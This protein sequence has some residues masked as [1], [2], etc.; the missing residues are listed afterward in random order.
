MKYFA[1]RNRFFLIVAIHFLLFSANVFAQT[2]TVIIEKS[3]DKVVI[4]GKIYFIHIVQAGHTLHSIAKVYNVGVDQIINENPSAQH[5]IKPGQALKIPQVIRHI[6]YNEGSNKLDDEFYYHKVQKNQTLYSL[7]N[8]YKVSQDAIVKHNPGADTLIKI[9]QIIQIPKVNENFSKRSYLKED[10]GFYYYRVRRKDTFYGLA[11]EYNTS[12]QEI[13]EANPFLSEG[14]KAGQ[15]IRIPKPRLASLELYVQPD[16]I[17]P[18]TI[19]ESYFVFNKNICDSIKAANTNRTIEMAVLLPL[20]SDF[21]YHMYL[22]DTVDRYGELLDE[23]ERLKKLRITSQ[24]FIEFY[25]GI[26]LA[27][28]VY[29]NRGYHV[30][31]SL[32]DTKRDSL[33]VFSALQQLETNLPD[34]IIGPVWPELFDTVAKFA[35]KHKTPVVSPFLTRIDQLE[36]NP[37]IFQMLPSDSVEYYHF[38]NFVNSASQSNIRYIIHE[39]DSLNENRISLL[40]RMLHVTWNNADSLIIRDVVFDINKAHKIDSVF[41]D[42]IENQVILITKDVGFANNVISKLNT[43]RSRYEIRVLGS[44]DWQ[45]EETIDLDFK[46][47]VDLGIYSPFYYNV[48]DLRTLQVL[49]EFKK[50]FGYVPERLSRQGYTF[51][52]YGYDVGM[53]FMGAIAN[54]DSSC[55]HCVDFFPEEQVLSNY[56]FNRYSPLAGFQNTSVYLIN[57]T[58]DFEIVTIHLNNVK[59]EIS[60]ATSEETP[61]L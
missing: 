12:I 38:S 14:L 48:K 11:R 1:V 41:C 5:V 58:K 54:F 27:A 33:A 18:D 50:K 16:T 10:Y 43:L 23:A 26:H 9:D 28:E 60:A 20:N 25:Q 15:L 24:W 61:E 17:V 52:L 44:S 8:R 47:F 21:H 59:R 42:S 35:Y 37:Y 30:K 6:P 19:P 40:K 4:D 56:R 22:R 32:F 53:L 34:I 13:K 36:E 45:R 39:N 57:Y 3:T 55:V 46:H 7:A 31:L 29:K 51:G 49:K 2:D